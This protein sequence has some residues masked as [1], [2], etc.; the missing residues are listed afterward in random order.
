MESRIDTVGSIFG[1]CWIRG[2]RVEIEDLESLEC[3]F[4]AYAW[5]DCRGV[6]AVEAQRAGAP[7]RRR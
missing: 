7:H 5:F 4:N 3:D 1:I 2:G 6:V